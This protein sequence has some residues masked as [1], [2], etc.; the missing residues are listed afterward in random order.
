M[1]RHAGSEEN[2][3]PQG[4]TVDDAMECLIL[5]RHNGLYHLGIMRFVLNLTHGCLTQRT[6]DNIQIYNKNYVNIS[7]FGRKVSYEL[8]SI[9]PV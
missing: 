6:L 7:E 1:P 2:R 8:N 3:M 4:Q 5:W 9:D